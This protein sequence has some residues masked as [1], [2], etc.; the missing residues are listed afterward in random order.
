M[1]FSFV[2]TQYFVDTALTSARDAG[3]RKRI[4]HTNTTDGLM[5]EKRT[6]TMC[7]LLSCHLCSYEEIYVFPT[8]Y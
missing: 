1:G 7:P 3:L 6:K 4:S 2:F 5:E 8:I